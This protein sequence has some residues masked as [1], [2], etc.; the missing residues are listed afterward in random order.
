M[1]NV[2]EYLRKF[3]SVERKTILDRKMAW[4]KKLCKIIEICAIGKP[5]SRRSACTGGPGQCG[6]W[7]PRKL[8][9]CKNCTNRGR[10]YQYLFLIIRR[11]F[12]KTNKPFCFPSSLGFSTFSEKNIYHISAYS[13]RGNY[14]FLNLTL[15]TVTFG[16]STQRCGNYSREET[17]Q[18][19]KLYEEIRYL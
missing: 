18:G 19:R 7:V 6:F 14:S 8:H 1:K 3:W 9:Y 12:S 11:V 16:N 2:D 4:L 5:C 10:F 15:C 13:F 17:I